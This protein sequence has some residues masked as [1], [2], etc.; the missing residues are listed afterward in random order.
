MV[1][2]TLM[3]DIQEIIVW[4]YCQTNQKCNALIKKNIGY[5]VVMEF[6]YTFA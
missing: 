5:F 2:K 3:A 6:I 4:R 1:Y